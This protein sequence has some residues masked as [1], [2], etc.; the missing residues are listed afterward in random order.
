MDALRWRHSAGA[1]GKGY[2]RANC[3]CKS[4][5]SQTHCNLLYVTCFNY[6]Y[7]HFNFY[8]PHAELKSHGLSGAAANGQ[9]FCSIRLGAVRGLPLPA[10]LHEAA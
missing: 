2:L 9:L 1:Q 6:I 8:A 7:F 3:V 5:Y 10:V 4:G